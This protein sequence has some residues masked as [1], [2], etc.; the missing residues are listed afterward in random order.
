MHSRLYPPNSVVRDE[1]ESPS[2]GLQPAAKPSQ[3]P[4]RGAPGQ[5]R[6][7]NLLFT[8][9]VLCQ[10]ELRGHG[11]DDEPRTRFL[12]GGNLTHVH[13]CFIRVEWMRSDDLPTSALARRRSTN[14]SYIHRWSARRDSNPR[15]QGCNLLSHHS[16]SDT[17]SPS[18]EFA[19]R[20]WHCSAG[21]TR[22]Y[23]TLINSQVLY[24]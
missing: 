3:L 19:A 24:H 7:V 10:T 16:T 8:R 11:A 12:Q 6:T 18:T 14:V 23:N 15:P 20:G 13:M 2:T 9:Q 22:T 1:F 21:R 17:G 4:D 5:D